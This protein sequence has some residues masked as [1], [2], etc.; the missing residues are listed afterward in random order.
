MDEGDFA[1]P[2]HKDLKRLIRARMHKTGESYT[3]SRLHILNKKSTE[4]PN[5][6]LMEPRPNYS[7]ITRMS[8]EA[9]QKATGCTWE[10]WVKALDRVKAYE[11]SHREIVAYIYRKYKTPSWW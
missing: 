3:T 4:I 1:M 8:D 7:A 11:M 10:R 9:L 2:K 6:L 5:G